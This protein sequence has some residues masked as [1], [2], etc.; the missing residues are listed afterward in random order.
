[1]LLISLTRWS[2]S[3]KP[4][5]DSL[6]NDC[7]ED[8]Q[9]PQY[10]DTWC[11]CPEGDVHWYDVRKEPDKAISFDFGDGCISLV[12][13]CKKHGMVIEKLWR[14]NDEGIYGEKTTQGFYID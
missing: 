14:D 12:G 5:I 6:F 9:E 3:S 4:F 7:M 2:T 8:T 10:T 11:E 13:E 1:M